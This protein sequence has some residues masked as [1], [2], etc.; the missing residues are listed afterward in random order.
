MKRKK[1]YKGE[2]NCPT[3]TTLR[4][5]LHLY[6]SVRVVSVD[7]EIAEKERKQDARTE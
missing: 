4:S 7:G 5:H 3:T 1:I 6:R 2:S